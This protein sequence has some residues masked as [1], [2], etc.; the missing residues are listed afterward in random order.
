MSCYKRPKVFGEKCLGYGISP[1]GNTDAILAAE[2]RPFTFAIDPE[3][4]RTAAIQNHP[5]PVSVPS[6]LLS[7]MIVIIEV[8]S[9]TAAVRR[10][11]TTAPSAFTLR[12]RTFGRSWPDPAGCRQTGADPKQTLIPCRRTL[13]VS[14]ALNQFQFRLIDFSFVQT[15]AERWE[16]CQDHRTTLRTSEPLV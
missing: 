4:T 9:S 13:G 7:R 5:K 14:T 8:T 10:P 15:D 12:G 1:Y 11:C 6:G 16:I 2:L 3:R